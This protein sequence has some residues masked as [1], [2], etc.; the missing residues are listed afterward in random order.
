M[1]AS[2]S[3]AR[4]SVASR[5]AFATSLAGVAILSFVLN[6]APY[7]L[8]ENPRSLGVDGDSWFH[9]AIQ[10]HLMDPRLF[11]GDPEVPGFYMV[12]RPPLEL[13]I[14]RSVVA[15]AGAAFSGDLLLA[16]ITGFWLINLLFLAGCLALARRAIGSR[17]GAVAFAAASAGLSLALAAWW[18][19]PFGAVIPHDLG[20]AFVPWLL[21]AYLR[22]DARPWPG[23]AVFAGIGLVANLYP[24]QPA[25]LAVA[26]LG[27]TLCAG[28][29]PTIPG[30]A[31]RAAAFLAGALP[32]ITTAA[33][34]TLRRL[35]SPDPNIAATAA[36]LLER[37]YGYLLPSSASVFV[38]RLADSTVWIF[39]IL[40]LA[41]ALVR[42]PAVTAEERRLLW[43]GAWVAV[44]S[45]FGLAVGAVFPP[46]LAFLFHRASA[47]LYIPAYLG[48]IAAALHLWKTR[49]VMRRLAAVA[50]ALLIAANAWWRTPLVSHV[51]GA[52]PIQAS[53]PYYELS[54]WARQHTPPGSLFLVPYRGRT[55]YFAF[56]IYAERPVLLHYALGE[57]VLAD[58]RLGAK[59]AALE[60]EVA[61]LYATASSTADFVR[62]AARHRVRFI[63]T[64][65]LTPRPPDLPVAW[66]NALFTVF[67][68]AE[69]R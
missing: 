60:R 65:D 32:A 16:N 64:D 29:Q 6:H 54:A 11:A 14:H 28:A 23:A 66:R 56:R 30:L 37:H 67:D 8:S 43:F 50:I 20:L 1:I 39:A 4:A 59:F 13:T 3:P 7:A 17:S 35:G 49:R 42:G 15:L 24:L 2:T 58:P 45:A 40:A 47:L 21:L 5:R 26:L 68:A 22:W 44:L 12:S 34:G 10:M 38:L 33:L 31:L 9:V 51:R 52:V 62:V 46:L 27:A 36:Q 69:A 55:T 25:F 61:P 41:G 19:M 48:S 53:T 63:I 18:G 57:M